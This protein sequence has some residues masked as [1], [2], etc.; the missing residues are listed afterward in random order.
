MGFFDFKV[1]LPDEDSHVSESSA[2]NYATREATAALDVLL[3]STSQ[4]FDSLALQVE[5][6]YSVFIALL[7]RLFTFAG[8]YPCFLSLLGKPLLTLPSVH[9]ERLPLEFE[10]SNVLL[11]SKSSVSEYTTRAA[12]AT[13]DLLRLTTG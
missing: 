9:V 10:R 4:V 7:V 8:H 13:L 5:H 6:L 1:E 11:V 12:S 2:L 3:L